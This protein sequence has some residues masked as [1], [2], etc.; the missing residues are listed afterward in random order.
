MVEQLQIPLVL[1]CLILA[2]LTGVMT[3]VGAAL[4]GSRPRSN[5]RVILV[6]VR[7]KKVEQPKS[8]VIHEAQ[9]VPSQATFSS[10]A[11]SED[12]LQEEIAARLRARHGLG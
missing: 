8:S 5:G 12:E 4:I 11:Q 3:V 7:R 10:R 2:Y 6:I 1:L 9:T